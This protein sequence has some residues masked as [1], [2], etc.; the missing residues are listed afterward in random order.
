[1]PYL[2]SLRQL[3]YLC[4]LAEHRHFGRAAEACFVTQST[5][6][7]GLQEMEQI[8]GVVLVE[9]TKRRVMVTPLGEEVVR[10][11]SQ[12]LRAAEDIVELAQAAGQPLSGPLRLG[13][14]PTIAPYLLPR[15]LSPLKQ[16]FPLL[17]L[18]LLEDRTARLLDQ[19][20][21]GHL[22][23]AVLALPYD[24]PGFAFAEIG[25][26]PFLLACPAD[27]PLAE[28]PIVS[29][30]DLAGSQLLLLEDGHCLRQHALA[31]CGLA[32]G[33]AGEEIRGT[34]LQT[35]IQMAASGLGVTLLPRL[36]VTAGALDGT[37]LVLRPL[38]GDPPARRLALAWRRSSP[39]QAEFVR[40]AAFVATVV[41]RQCNSSAW[42]GAAG[43]AEPPLRG[44]AE[45]ASS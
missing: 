6:S 10:R 12:V 36:A 25:E 44:P 9:R 37:G 30:E 5:L 33:R 11:A 43:G 35:V 4:A 39:R 40:L 3:R 42:L 28:Q 13:V 45:S 17:R 21:A 34:S 31:V 27:H 41:D 38:A 24:A 19:L 26:D 16:Q 7:A 2:P 18:Y 20:S 22:D 32:A 29:V 8:L 15:L 1:M 14:I 23:A